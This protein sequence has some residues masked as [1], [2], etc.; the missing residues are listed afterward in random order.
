MR[1]KDPTREQNQTILLLIRDRNGSKLVKKGEKWSS[2][3]HLGGALPL[4]G[5]SPLKLSH[6]GLGTHPIPCPSQGI[7]ILTQA[8]IAGYHNFDRL[9]VG[10]QHKRLQTNYIVG[11]LGPA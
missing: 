4:R 9:L 7:T 3:R 5:Q 10:R 2:G 8:S 11:S 6:I 1:P